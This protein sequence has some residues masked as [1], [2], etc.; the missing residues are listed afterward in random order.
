VTAFHGHLGPYVVLGYR[1]GLLARQRTGTGGYFDIEAQPTTRGKPPES[2]F[3]DGVQLG[4][5]ATTGKGNLRPAV[6]DGP[7]RVTFVGKNGRRITLELQPSLV[8]WL[9]AS[10]AKHGVG[11]TGLWIFAAPIETLFVTAP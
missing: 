8:P 1:M 2:C 3:I 7:P 10:I 4:T 6:T 11:P 9:R 5:G